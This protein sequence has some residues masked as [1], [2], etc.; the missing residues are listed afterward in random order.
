[1]V[2]PAPRH[3]GDVEE[4]VDAAE[5]DEGAVIGDVLDH[6]LHDLAV[7]E[8]FQGLGLLLLH[9]FFQNGLAGKDDV[10]AL[11]VDLD[12]AHFELFAAQAVQIAHRPQ[13][14]LRSGQERAHADVDR[15]AALDALDDPSF[16]RGALA[17]GALDLVPDL[18]PLGLFPRK[19]DVAFGI[20]RLLQ[21]HIH[22]IADLDADPALLIGELC[23]RNNPFGFETDIDDHAAAGNRDDLAAN[24]FSLGKALRSSF[25]GRQKCFKAVV[26]VLVGACIRLAPSWGASLRGTSCGCLRV[27]DIQ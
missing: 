18:H 10:A 19:D 2:D 12:D 8:H 11:L 16:D 7:L 27:V 14:D 4:P 23:D 20:L 6:A 26:F 25:V 15:Q 5:V 22:G 1:M 21:K 17:I 3:V 24:H 13:V 9:R